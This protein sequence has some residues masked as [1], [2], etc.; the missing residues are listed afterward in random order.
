M[1]APYK[2]RVVSRGRL[3]L[4]LTYLPGTSVGKKITPPGMGRFQL[5]NL[6]V[7]MYGLEL[8]FWV[9]IAI[10]VSLTLTITLITTLKII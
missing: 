4:P 2:S 10:I 9:V 3:L 5:L 7:C 8:R 6:G 1:F